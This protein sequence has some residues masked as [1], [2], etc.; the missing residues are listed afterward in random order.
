MLRIIAEAMSL[1]YSW[2][3]DSSAEFEAGFIAQLTIIG[4]QVVATVSNGS[5]P[6]GII[7]DQKTRAFTGTAWDE[8]VIVPAAGVPGPNNTLVTPV[9][10]KAELNNPNVLP[11]TFISIPV[12]VQL[13]PRNGVIVFPAGTPLNCD[14]LG[15]GIFNAIK[16]NVRY[17]FSQAN[18]IGDDTTFA[19]QRVTVWYSRIIFETNIFEPNQ[20][21]SVNTNLFCSEFGMLTS[22]QPAPNY[23]VVALCLAPPSPITPTLQA[24]WL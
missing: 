12:A 23:P 22:R 10:I 9:D 13:I 7:D 21:Y 6:I 14:L 11:N 4:N 20:V 24:L 18:I 8:T 16:T 15:T 2:A 3:V 5:A 19:S 1:P 17:N